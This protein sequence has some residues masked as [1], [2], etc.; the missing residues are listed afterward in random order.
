VGKV[1]DPGRETGDGGQGAFWFVRDRFLGASVNDY[2]VSDGFVLSLSMCKRG[3]C[4]SLLRSTPM[5]MELLVSPETSALKAQTPG[6]YPKRHN[7]TF[8]RREKFE[9][10]F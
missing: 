3:F 8:N 4:L 2:L 1:A 5:K 9:I 7:T 10:R 6:D